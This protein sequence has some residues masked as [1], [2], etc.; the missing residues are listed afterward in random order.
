MDTTKLG[1]VYVTELDFSL[2]EFRN[3]PAFSVI[4][5]NPYDKLPR[6]FYSDY[7]A[8]EVKL[9]TYWNRYCR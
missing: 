7:L 9:L 4:A 6:I 5:I 1:K 8:G 3:N 2:S